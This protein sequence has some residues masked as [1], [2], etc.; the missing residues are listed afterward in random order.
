LSV[1]KA[2]VTK[3]VAWLENSMGSQLLN[4]SSKQ[5]T[6]TDAG[7]RVLESAQELLDRY[8]RL[9]ADVRDSVHLR[10]HKEDY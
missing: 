8:E 3:N 6:L 9:E 10:K 4:R 7:L 2:T 1:S 5:V